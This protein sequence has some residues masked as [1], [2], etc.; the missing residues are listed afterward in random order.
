MLSMA[1]VALV[2]AE[3][4][5]ALAPA[6]P[7]GLL[8]TTARR[9]GACSMSNWRPCAGRRRADRRRR[10][11]R[12]RRCRCLQARSGAGRGR[13]ARRR[14]RRPTHPGE[15]RRRVARQPVVLDVRRR[16]GRSSWRCTCVALLLCSQIAHSTW[17]KPSRRIICMSSTSALGNRGQAN[18]LPPPRQ[19]CRVSPRP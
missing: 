11:H 13:S 3:R 2:S 10:W 12:D 8:P 18:L 5:R 19:A 16:P 4:R 15:Q 7:N 17:S 1:I 14:V 6:S 9:Y